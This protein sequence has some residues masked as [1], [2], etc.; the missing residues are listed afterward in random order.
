VEYKEYFPEALPEPALALVLTAVS[1][2]SDL[3]LRV[4]NG[5]FRQIEYCIKVYGD[6]PCPEFSESWS[7]AYKNHIARFSVINAS[8]RNPA[9]PAMQKICKLIMKESRS[10][11]VPMFWC[12]LLMSL[13][14]SQAKVEEKAPEPKSLIDTE[15][16][17][18]AASQLDDL[19]DSDDEH[20]VAA[21]PGPSRTT[22]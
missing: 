13:L 11:L 22:E 10:V 12:R 1:T 18:A 3:L 2:F 17:K 4:L 15:R 8:S 21:A 14:R 5:A 20:G 6:R 19:P 7:S 16:A 9:K